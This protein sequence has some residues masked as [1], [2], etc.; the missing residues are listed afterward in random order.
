MADK[1]MMPLMKSSHILIFC[2]FF[3]LLFAASRLHPGSHSYEKAA[4]ADFTPPKF[5]ST[6]ADS[7]PPKS[8]GTYI[9]LLKEIPD[10]RSRTKQ[11]TAPAATTSPTTAEAKPAAKKTAKPLP[12]RPPEKKELAARQTLPVQNPKPPAALTPAPSEQLPLQENEPPLPETPLQDKPQEAPLPERENH[13]RKLNSYVLEI[14]QT[15]QIGN[16]PYLLNNDYAN[17]N[18]VTTNIFY[19]DR[20]LARAHPSGNRASHCVGITFEVFFRAMQERNRRLGLSPNDFNGMNWDELFDFMLLWY[21]ATGPKQSSNLTIAVEKYGIGTRI[22]NLAEAR[23][24]DFIDF[25]RTNGT[26]HTAV[27][28]DWVRDNERIVGIRYWSSQS[29]TNGIAYNEE[30]FNIP[31]SA[32]RPYGNVMQQPLYIA[33]VLPVADYRNFRE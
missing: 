22:T 29:S 10:E 1:G 2:L 15:Y 17:Y 20:L 12:E 5:P 11:E 8:P 7:A 28:I 33:R 13:D 27:F 18:G 9:E 23:P 16:F 30:Y 26:G 3:S 32:G 4:L 25:S 21:V 14:I 19:Q 24:G 6:T 31:N